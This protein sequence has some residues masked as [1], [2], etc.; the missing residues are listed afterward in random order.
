MY[1]KFKNIEHVCMKRMAYIHCRHLMALSY[2][3]SNAQNHEDFAFNAPPPPHS[4]DYFGNILR[5]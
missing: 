5:M 2:H 4:K 1:C 3:F